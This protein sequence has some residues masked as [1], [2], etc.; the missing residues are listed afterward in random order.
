MIIEYVSVLLF[1]SGAAFKRCN[2]GI[3]TSVAN[4]FK[5]K[6]FFNLIQIKS[7]P[8]HFKALV[9]AIPFSSF[10]CAITFALSHH[11]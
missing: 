3:V 7:Q 8:S 11:T 6:K 9:N 4:V 10:F 5:K 2:N 1:Y